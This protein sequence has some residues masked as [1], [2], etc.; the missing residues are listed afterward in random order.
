ML[1]LRDENTYE[2]IS[3]ASLIAKYSFG[4]SHL[5]LAPF[6]HLIGEVPSLEV[7]SKNF[8][9]ILRIAHNGGILLRE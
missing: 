5:L 7:T 4:V 1:A 3:S 2:E 9:A 8:L 6:G